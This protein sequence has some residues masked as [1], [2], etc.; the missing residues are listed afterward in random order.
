MAGGV[1]AQALRAIKLAVARPF[2]ANDSQQLLAVRGKFLDALGWPIFAHENF[3]PRINRYRARQRQFSGISPMNA[4]LANQL[5]LGREM[6]HSRIVRFND[7]DITLGIAAHSFWF[8]LV[9]LRHLPE[10][11]E[12]ALW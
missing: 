7:Y 5:T 2:A 8:A 1:E 12:N 11:E 3:A 6:I 10:S 9:R 4:P